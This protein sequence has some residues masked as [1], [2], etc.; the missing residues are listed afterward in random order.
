MFSAVDG[1]RAT[2]NINVA[3]GYISTFNSGVNI[4]TVIP[5]S[6]GNTLYIGG[7]CVPPGQSDDDILWM[8]VNNQNA[9]R[10]S[11][12]KQLGDASNPDSGLLMALDS[13]ENVYMVGRGYYDGSNTPAVA[14]KYTSTGTL[15]WQKEYA[16]T[17]Q[18][19]IGAT[20]NEVA[21]ESG[22]GNIYCSGTTNQLI[23]GSYT[24]I[25]VLVKYNS[26]GTVQYQEET[27]YAN[28]GSLVY[29]FGRIS[30]LT[31]GL[32]N[33]LYMTG[34]R[35][36]YDFG[37]T[38]FYT[39]GALQKR[40]ANGVVEWDYTSS[41]ANANV[42][43]T[44][45]VVD[46]SNNVFITGYY[47][48]ASGDFITKLYANGV[49]DWQTQYIDTDITSIGLDDTGNVYMAGR[50]TPDYNNAFY[51]SIDTSTGNIN[52]QTFINRSTGNLLI[53]DINYANNFVYLG[54]YTQA[55]TGIYDSFTMKLPSNGNVSG[56]YGEFS[57]SAANVVESSVTLPTGGGNLDFSSVTYDEA[58]ASFNSTN[59]IVGRR[60]IPL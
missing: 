25:S 27:Y 53:T 14:T 8:K 44:Q 29:D 57:F 60:I 55:Y 3:D 50:L 33:R 40:Y 46:S 37:N 16:D 41:S 58:T 36:T 23:G 26:S 43:F 13:S 45:S 22:G 7:T 17:S 30:D 42:R 47:E 1:F 49:V 15:T 24:G 9:A 56:T 6:D 19:N 11:V 2:S 51:I 39:G 20:Y 28:S 59:G 4:Y 5:T 52:S 21:V 35:V 48:N 34:D 32:G 54:G 10:I 18:I 12:E 38:T 31:V